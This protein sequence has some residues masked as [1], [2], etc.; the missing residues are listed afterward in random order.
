M[1][2]LGH[3][4]SW[5]TLDL[6]SCLSLCFSLFLSFIHSYN[7]FCFFLS[8]SVQIFQKLF[9]KYL[10]HAIESI[11]N[12]RKTKLIFLPFSLT[13][14]RKNIRR[15]ENTLATKKKLKSMDPLRID[16]IESWN[17]LTMAFAM[18]RF[19]SWCEFYVNGLDFAYSH[20]ILFQLEIS[21]ILF[22]RYPVWLHCICSKL[23][24]SFSCSRFG[25]F[26]RLVSVYLFLFFFTSHCSS[27][28]TFPSAYVMFWSSK[29]KNCHRNAS[30]NKFS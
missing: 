5:E 14:E 4:K 15:H 13:A 30:A 23:S 26:S 7:F 16:L 21:A 29:N 18:C 12:R 11:S 8:Y 6:P 19:V 9:L 17:S 28:L 22:A 20:I 10:E 25:F 24:I 2:F 1:K 3:T 27:L